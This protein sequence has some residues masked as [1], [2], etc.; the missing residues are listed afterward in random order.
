[1]KYK[2]NKIYQYTETVVVEANSEREAKDA[3]MSV[4]GEHNHDDSLHDCEV[5]GTVEED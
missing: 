1:M 4:D 3:A 5:I 2:V